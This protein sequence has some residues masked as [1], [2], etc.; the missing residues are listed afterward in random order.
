MKHAWIFTAAAVALVGVVSLAAAESPSVR[1]PYY[2]D[3]PPEGVSEERAKEAL[4]LPE[5]V[6]IH[7]FLDEEE[8]WEFFKEKEDIKIYARIRPGS[9][10]KEGVGIGT[11]DAP[12]CRVMQMLM[13][14]G[15]LPQF[16]PY[17][18]TSIVTHTDFNEEYYCQY[19][20]LP[21]ILKDRKYNLVGRRLNL[22]EDGV[23]KLMIAWEKDDTSHPC[24]EEQFREAV[25]KYK[26]NSLL[27]EAN[28]GYWYLI[29]KEGNTKTEAH[30]YIYTDPG[31]TVPPFIQNW[32][33]DD[34]IHGVYE[35]G[36]EQLAKDTTY[37]PCECSPTEI[38]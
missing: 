3:N 27:T 20:D 26:G 22:S 10:I 14:H 2:V 17:I 38:P 13:D 18:Q 12:P 21:G 34:A 5:G 31:G 9:K 19:L 35:A 7:D 28:L 16:M 37:P 33:V 8:G 30:Y 4:K 23:C 1:P 15:R 32:F 29:G 25:E 6:V 24:S 11:F 36:R